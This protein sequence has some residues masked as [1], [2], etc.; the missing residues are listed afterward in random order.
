MHAPIALLLYTNTPHVAG[1]LF[2][3]AQSDAKVQAQTPTQETK[4]EKFEPG[5]V[6]RF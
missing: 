2:S 6:D 5:I 4:F 3:M 1:T